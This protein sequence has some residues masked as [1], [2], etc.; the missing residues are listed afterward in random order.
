VI[1]IAKKVKQSVNHVKR[2]FIG[3][4]LPESGGALAGTLGGNNH[5][6]QQVRCRALPFFL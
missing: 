4:A 5:V 6:S 1:V 3:H 2:E